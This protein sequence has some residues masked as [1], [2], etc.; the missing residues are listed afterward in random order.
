MSSKGL[1]DDAAVDYVFRV[2]TLG[3]EKCGKTSYLMTATGEE[4][5]SR[6]P[7]DPPLKFETIVNY[8]DK[9]AKVIAYDMLGRRSKDVFRSDDHY[10][11]LH[12]VILLADM[13]VEDSHATFLKF[14]WHITAKN[15]AKIPMVALGTMYDK[16]EERKWTKQQA[17][18]ECSC[19]DIRYVEISS[20]TGRN[21][22]GSLKVLVKNM[23]EWADAHPVTYKTGDM[24]S[25][26]TFTTEN[27]EGDSEA[28]ES[29]GGCC[30][31]S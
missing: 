14:Y 9:T 30:V 1:G 12:G 15:K 10:Q 28:V 16:K 7:K 13:T 8:N 17:K 18:E 19:A 21:V 6:K 5:P 20:K 29:A 2:Q 25:D 24:K 27:M 4:C 23:M 31:V 26:P 11:K 3:S 22:E